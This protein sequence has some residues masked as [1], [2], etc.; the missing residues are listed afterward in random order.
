MV[1]LDELYLTLVCER[2]SIRV[3]AV[4]MDVCG[5]LLR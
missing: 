4:G 5:C 2:G 3:G 1:L